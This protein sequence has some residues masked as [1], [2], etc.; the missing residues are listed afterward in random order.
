VLTKK[1]AA[2]M[3]EF[4]EYDWAAAPVNLDRRVTAWFVDC[5]NLSL[6]NHTTLA[7]CWT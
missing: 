3:K 4:Y 7:A 2:V 1:G 6:T 5:Y